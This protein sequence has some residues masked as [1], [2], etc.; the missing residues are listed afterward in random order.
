MSI[1]CASY[2][3]VL[4][5]S[6]LDPISILLFFLARYSHSREC[7]TIRAS[8]L[9]ARPSTLRADI[10]DTS[11]H[12]FRVRTMSNNYRKTV[13]DFRRKLPL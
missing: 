5:P 9:H 12:Q 10:I 2:G 11:Y 1:K 13:G 4:K 8:K 3:F 7:S 6:V